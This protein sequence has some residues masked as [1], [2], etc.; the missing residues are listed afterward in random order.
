MKTPLWRVA[1]LNRLAL[2]LTH[3][4]APQPGCVCHDMYDAKAHGIER[5]EVAAY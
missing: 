2:P 3:L 4:R 5:V 1:L